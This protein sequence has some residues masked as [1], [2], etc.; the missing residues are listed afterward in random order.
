MIQVV[1]S[2]GGQ[3]GIPEEGIAK[4]SG[5]SKR[6]EGGATAATGIGGK[7]LNALKKCGMGWMFSV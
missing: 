2:R 7:P 6:R 3:G 5:A 1:C 4:A